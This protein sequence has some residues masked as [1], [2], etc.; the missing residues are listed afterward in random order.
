[1]KMYNAWENPKQTREIRMMTKLAK[2][3]LSLAKQFK[4]GFP[5]K[6]RNDI[7]GG[8]DDSI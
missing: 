1:M 3:P 4:F 6:L 7:F 2:R 5:D 8:K